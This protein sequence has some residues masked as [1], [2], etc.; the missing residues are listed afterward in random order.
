MVK[1]TKD[2]FNIKSLSFVVLV[3][4][5]IISGI[6]FISSPVQT[7]PVVTEQQTTEVSGAGGKLTGFASV[8][9]SATVS[10]SA[11][12]ASAASAADMAGA[13]TLTPSG[14]RAPNTIICNATITDSNG[15]LDVI[16]VTG[17]LYHNVT[18]NIAAV[19]PTLVT[20]AAPVNT[21]IVY[22]N[23]SCQ[24]TTA[25]NSNT[26]D[27]ID[28][29]TV[30]YSCTFS[31]Q[32]W[33]QQTTAA[34][35]ADAVYVCNMTPYDTDGAGSNDTAT[36]EL[37]SSVDF[38][39]NT[40]IAFGTVSLGVNSSVF[41]SQV[42]NTGNLALDIGFSGYGVAS[43]DY[44][45]LN[46]TPTGN[47]SNTSMKYRYG[48]PVGFTVSEDMNQN[49]SDDTLT[50]T[51]FDLAPLFFNTLSGGQLTSDTAPNLATLDFPNASIYWALITPESGVGGT[52]SGTI[53]ATGAAG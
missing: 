45:S 25:G 26:C 5:L 8:T 48:S 13:T 27:G 36:I 52:C 32:P 43:K 22:Y 44:M 6:W 17:I 7:E 3:V 47:I 49:I 53:T 15:C 20:D 41:T 11:P 10:N 12:V 4:I 2:Y 16:N 40:T 19:N 30:D 29:N 24:A 51:S 42:N 21:S 35:A 23:A 33:A 50:N 38:E 31:M 28:D 18:D 1:K 9:T 37:A 39:F 34:L 14:S 46:C